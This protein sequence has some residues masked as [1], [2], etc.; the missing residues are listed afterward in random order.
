MMFLLAAV[1][2]VLPDSY[3]GT[4][5]IGFKGPG[6]VAGDNMIWLKRKDGGRVAWGWRWTMFGNGGRRS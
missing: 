6:R 3:I 5:C 2:W 1:R 4:G